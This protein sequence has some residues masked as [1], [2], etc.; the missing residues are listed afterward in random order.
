MQHEQEES[1]S[2]GSLLKEK[3]RAAK[4]NPR[5]VYGYAHYGHYAVDA[6]HPQDGD[7]WAGL[8]QRTHGMHRNKLVLILARPK[9]GK[10]RF[11]AGLLPN[12]AEQVPSGQCVRV[13]TFETSVEE[14]VK[15]SACT[16]AGIPNPTAVD[17]GTLTDEQL[18]AYLQAVDYVDSL[19]IRY[20]STPLAFH[21][22]ER[23]VRNK[24]VP[25]FLWVLDH[26]GLVTD[27][28][29]D[30]DGTGGLRALSRNLAILCH[31]VATGIVIGH[32][33]RTSVGGEPGIQS[34]ALS[35]SFGKDFDEAWFL[36]KIWEGHERPKGLLDDGEPV[37]L[38][39][40]SRHYAGGILWLWWDAN[41]GQFRQLSP[42][43]FEDMPRPPR[44]RERK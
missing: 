12:I 10:T 24:K 5:K 9:V 44:K 34:I 36:W 11:I 32:L 26:F 13:F 41:M 40:E 8:D 1:Q 39:I 29:L 25:T 42:D 22:L 14:W 4:A 6:E 20:Y 3:A 17:E 31:E 28:G 30:R 7:E 27:N 16:V 2:V 37:M 35:D 15:V 38:K 33:N 19:P 23:R 43:E 21:E 18:E